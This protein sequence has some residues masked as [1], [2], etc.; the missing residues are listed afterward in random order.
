MAGDKAEHLMWRLMNGELPTQHSP[1]VIVLHIGT[2][3]LAGV[4]VRALRAWCQCQEGLSK[5]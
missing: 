1:K 4:L 2:N 5:A 3:D